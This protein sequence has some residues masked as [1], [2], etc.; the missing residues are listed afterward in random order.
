M[1][2]WDNGKIRELKDDEVQKIQEK[3]TEN[4]YQNRIRQRTK[5][6]F[7]INSLIN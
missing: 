4:A 3:M 2:M 7:K 1:K 5:Q 6:E